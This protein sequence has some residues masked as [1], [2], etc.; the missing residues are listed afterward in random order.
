MINK[1]C[2]Q[3]KLAR[4]SSTPGKTRLLNVYTINEALQLIDLPGYG[5]AKVAKDEKMRWMDMMEVISRT[6]RR[7]ATCCI[8]WI[9]GTTRRLTIGT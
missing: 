3:N 6:P 5:F 1:L 7:C 8:S 9:S 2:R 4:T